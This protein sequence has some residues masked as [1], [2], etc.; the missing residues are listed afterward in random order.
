MM[1][2]NTITYDAETSEAARRLSEHI[3]KAIGDANNVMIIKPTQLIVPQGLFKLARRIVFPHHILKRR[4][5]ARGRAM[6][7][8]WRRK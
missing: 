8:K 7:L 1:W 3:A 5:G 4:K 2:A 6:T